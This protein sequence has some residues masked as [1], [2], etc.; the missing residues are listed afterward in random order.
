[1]TWSNDGWSDS[2]KA[3]FF[4]NTVW[5]VVFNSHIVNFYQPV[6]PNNMIENGRCQVPNAAR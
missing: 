2:I 5:H 3:H 1:M 4:W 6:V